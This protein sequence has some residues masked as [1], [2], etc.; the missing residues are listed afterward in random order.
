[1]NFLPS[2]EL[3]VA[4]GPT[5]SSTAN[6]T[7]AV[8]DT[9]DCDGVCIVAGA[10]DYAAAC[11]FNVITGTTSDASG[12]TIATASASTADHAV[13][14]DLHQP[15]KRYVKVTV[16]PGAGAVDGAYVHAWK[17]GVAKQPTSQGSTS[18]AASTVLVGS[19]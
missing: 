14:F 4:L 1:M 8:I 19:S 9:A 7:S 10:G 5:T 12:S 17:Y 18:V 16:E 11:A 13:I 2:K 6:S 15:T 3:I